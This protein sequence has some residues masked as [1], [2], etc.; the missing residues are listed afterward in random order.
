MFA[1]LFFFV[2]YFFGRK[3]HTCIS[4]STSFYHNF[5]CIYAACMHV[6]FERESICCILRIPTPLILF[7]CVILS[8]IIE[9]EKYPPIDKLLKGN[10]VIMQ[11]DC[12][13]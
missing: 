5:F 4:L 13:M 10:S 2:C 12:F 11:F 7:L 1:I 9:S 3:Y 6:F 8:K